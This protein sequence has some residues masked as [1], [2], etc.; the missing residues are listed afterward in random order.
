[1]SGC[2][3]KM[4]QAN[5]ASFKSM[6]N[7]VADIKLTLK[8]NEKFNLMFHPLD[9]NPVSFKGDWDLADGKYELT[10]RG[11]SIDFNSLFPNYD[12]IEV[13]N[14]ETIKF[15]NSLEGLWIWGIYCYKSEK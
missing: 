6:G 2:A 3:T 1:M 14:E 13:V 15:S 5:E 7:D 12:G 4:G 11:K 10:F 8:A 9:A